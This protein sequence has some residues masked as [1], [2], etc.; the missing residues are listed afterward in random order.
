MANTIKL[1]VVSPDKPGFA[2]DVTLVTLPGTAGE[3][4]VM[5]RHMPIMATIKPGTLK[6]TAN[7]KKELYFVSKGFVEVNPKSVTVLAEAYE[8]ADEIDAERAQ[9]SMEKAKE[10]LASNKDMKHNLEV[11]S[12]LERAQ[13]R[14][15]V[16]EESKQAGS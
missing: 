8:K 15:K 13:G 11:L 7:G 1:Q 5:A 10:L 4:G 14:L 16:I 6:V 2:T 12:S 3:F 9:K